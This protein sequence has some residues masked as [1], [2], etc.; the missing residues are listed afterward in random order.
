MNNFIYLLY[1]ELALFIPA[2]PYVTI[3]SI[4]LRVIQYLHIV[5]DYTRYIVYI[6]SIICC[7]CVYAK[8]ICGCYNSFALVIIYKDHKF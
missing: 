1:F 7:F 2:V 4:K 3:L 8:L 6:L 5:S